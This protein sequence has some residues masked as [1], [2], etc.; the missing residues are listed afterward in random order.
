MRL[1][2]MLVAAMM[3]HLFSILPAAA[4]DLSLPAGPVILEIT[5]QIA[6]ENQAGGRGLT[7]RC[8]MRCHNAIR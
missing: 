5:G 1:F 7:W 4:A 6:H 2:K 3:L 8:W